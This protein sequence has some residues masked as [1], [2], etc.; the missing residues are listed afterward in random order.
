MRFLE[1]FFFVALVLYTTAI[2]ADWFRGEL[3]RWMVITFGVG[4][5]SDMIGTFAFCA[6]V[7]DVWR[8]TPHILTGTASLV[9]MA[10]HFLWAV[11]AMRRGGRSKALF[12]RWSIPAWTLWLVSFLSGA[13][14]R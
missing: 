2:W 9:I 12:Q 11:L 3:R 7:T 1:L 4:L 5:A 10:L 13:F 8:P 6:T 14:I